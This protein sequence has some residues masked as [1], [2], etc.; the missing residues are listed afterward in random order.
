MSQ[1]NDERLDHYQQGGA[2][3]E[4]LNDAEV[5]WLRDVMGY[6]GN[7]LMDLRE[8]WYDDGSPTEPPLP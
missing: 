3:A 6:V 8:Q 5:E 4:Q 2:T 1:L 7:D